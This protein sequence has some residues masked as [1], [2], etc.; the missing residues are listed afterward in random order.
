MKNKLAI[1]LCAVAALLVGF[2]ASAESI[3]YTVTGW[4]VTCSSSKF[5]G[6]QGTC[7]KGTADYGSLSNGTITGGANFTGDS[8]SGGVL[9]VD[10]Y[11]YVTT[12]TPG[13]G[14]ATIHSTSWFGLAPGG[15]VYTGGGGLVGCTP[16]ADVICN[17][18]NTPLPVAAIG[19]YPPG[20]TVGG[21]L[22]F[23]VNALASGG[24]NKA[25]QNYALTVVP[26]PGTAL[27]LG[28]GLLGL[29]ISGRR[30]K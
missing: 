25:W 27:L 16:T 8:M 20:S 12:A 21:T 11:V 2:S 3:N 28:M 24:S 9:T 10:S 4:Q 26:E 29:A 5:T 17:T 18:P 22:S 13:V 6:I 23:L 7:I 14:P 19:L 1:A 15:T 30:E